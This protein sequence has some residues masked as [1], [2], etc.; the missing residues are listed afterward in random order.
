MA[1]CPLS[2]TTAAIKKRAWRAKCGEEQRKKERIARLAREKKL[3]SP[4]RKERQRQWYRNYQQKHS[5]NN[6]SKEIHTSR[7]C[8]DDKQQ[9]S[10]PPDEESLFASPN[11]E[12]AF[13][14]QSQSQFIGDSSDLMD[15]SDSHPGSGSPSNSIALHSIPDLH[16]IFK[17][18][19]TD[20]PCP[21][22]HPAPPPNPLSWLEI[23]SAF[24]KAA[25]A[26][27]SIRD[28]L[29]RST[30][31]PH[32]PVTK[33]K[34]T[35]SEVNRN[36]STKKEDWKRQPPLVAHN[37][38]PPF[39]VASTTGNCSTE[40]PL[41]ARPTTGKSDSTHC[42][43][44]G[45]ADPIHGP[46][47]PKVSAV[48]KMAHPRST[49]TA[50]QPLDRKRKQLARGP[51]T[52]RKKL[53]RGPSDMGIWRVEKIGVCTMKQ[54]VEYFRTKWCGFERREWVPRD[55]F[56]SACKADLDRESLARKERKR[57]KHARITSI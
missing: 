33:L 4:V 19:R 27:P 43:P 30:P 10:A 1:G 31:L 42:P 41:P 48:P 21:N 34:P 36:Q 15:D 46:G 55:N 17:R 45:L 16:T 57:L 38:Q 49:P 32:R 6:P 51:R 3:G 22:L 25:A 20:I 23:S 50:K 29:Q 47:T 13:S 54:G 35:P 56:S 18:K 7:S 28:P 8:G 24:Q 26:P 9:V 39:S 5:T 53:N 44:T 52:R 11:L 2:N 12:G 40:C 37:Y 14:P